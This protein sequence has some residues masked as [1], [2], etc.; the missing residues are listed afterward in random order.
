MLQ[1][2]EALNRQIIALRKLSLSSGNYSQLA[3][4]ENEF[5]ARWCYSYAGTSLSSEEVHQFYATG[6]AHVNDRYGTK[7]NR[8][9]FA[10]AMLR[11]YDHIHRYMNELYKISLMT[12]FG[13]DAVDSSLMKQSSTTSVSNE[14]LK[15]LSVPS[16]N[17]NLKIPEITYMT[18]SV[19]TKERS[20]FSL[21]KY[22]KKAKS[23]PDIDLKVIQSLTDLIYLPLKDPIALSS[24]SAMQ[25]KLLDNIPYYM[26]DE[27]YP[28]MTSSSVQS[29]LDFM[30]RWIKH[31]RSREHPVI[32]GSLMHYNFQQLHPFVTGN[33][34][35]SQ[36]LLNLVLLKYGFP[37]MI[38][39]NGNRGAT[40]KLKLDI[41]KER[42]DLLPLVEFIAGEMIFTLNFIKHLYEGIVDPL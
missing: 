30:W 29:Q 6:Q 16:S 33:L 19:L 9:F 3:F 20:T 12:A 34:R 17:F 24:D 32:L 22:R 14:T 2:I 38:L 5:K 27:V 31:G 13:V 26:L 1:E 10:Y 36:L 42:G 18:T 8:A 11:S 40:Y 21:R 4:V 23:F 37:M 28:D 7:D 39:R 25:L 15:I 35:A 41:A